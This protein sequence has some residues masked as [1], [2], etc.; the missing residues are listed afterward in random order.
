MSTASG[1]PHG[2]YSRH[3]PPSLFSDEG[4][5]DPDN[6]SDP[7]KSSHPQGNTK[8]PTNS[9]QQSDPFV[10]QAQFLEHHMWLLRTQHDHRLY[11]G[12]KH[13]ISLSFNK[14]HPV[15]P[16]QEEHPSSR[17]HSRRQ[18]NGEQNSKARH[19]DSKTCG[20][21]LTEQLSQHHS[22]LLS[23]HHSRFPSQYHSHPLVILFLCIS[24]HPCFQCPQHYGIRSTRTIFGISPLLSTWISSQVEALHGWNSAKNIWEPLHRATKS[25]IYLLQD[26]HQYFLT[27]GRMTQWTQVTKTDFDAFR[28]MWINGTLP[29]PPGKPPPP[30]PTPTSS[31]S[32]SMTLAQ[33][34]QRNVKRNIDDYPELKKDKEWEKWS[35]EVMTVAC[36]HETQNVLDRNYVPRTREEYDLFAKQN[37]YMYSVFM[38]KMKVHWGE[39]LLRKHHSTR[40]AQEFYADLSDYF[41]KSNVASLAQTDLLREITTTSLNPSTWKGSYKDFF[42]VYMKRLHDHDRITDLSEQLPDSVKMTLLS[43]AVCQVSE[44]NSIKTDNDKEI[45]HGRPPLTWQK[46]QGLLFQVCAAMDHAEA[47]TSR[48]RSK[49]RFNVNTHEQGL[50][51]DDFDWDDDETSTN[52]H[53]HEDVDIDDQLQDCLEVNATDG[54]PRRP[55]MNRK[56]WNSLSAE[57]KTVWDTMT[58]DAKAKLLGYKPLDTQD[59]MKLETNK[60][61]VT[62]HEQTESAHSPT[63]EQVD[64]DLDAYF[65]ELVE[66]STGSNSGPSWSVL[67]HERRTYIVSKHKSKERGSLVDR[68]ANGGIAGS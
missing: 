66:N 63:V 47:V 32:S 4:T 30:S 13:H 62:Q 57:D 12:E 20:T 29:V 39:H 49:S 52:S 3:R 7:A 8:T 35:R 28:T 24:N 54:R 14:T 36:N 11:D 51:S 22:R 9:D 17:H 25:Q 45:A 61:E 10:P 40:N 37:I 34:F 6:G 59:R 18:D 21:N 1:N 60:Y 48:G 67:T 23:Q 15:E 5:R 46:Y 64:E 58:D 26:A 2:R 55:S 19:R 68:G 41:L 33:Q 65:T 43:N 38:K 56:Y 44:L 53:D 27:E 42:V 16:Q 31:G 50:T